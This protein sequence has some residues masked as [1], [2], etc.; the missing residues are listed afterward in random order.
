VDLTEGL[1]GYWPLDA[2]SGTVASDA[3]GLDN[4]GTVYGN[5]VATGGPVGG[6][7]DFDGSDD[8]VVIADHATLD[9]VD[10]ITIATWIRPEQKATQYVIKKARKDSV[11]GYELGL[12]RGGTIF[13]RFN[14]DSSGN[15]YRLDSNTSYPFNGQ[16]WIHVAATYD[17]TAIKIYVNGQLEATKNAVFQIAANSVALGIGA[18]DNGYR[19]LKGGMDDVRIYQRALSAAEVQLLS[20]P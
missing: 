17:G 11:D 2:P 10:S 1:V 19:G 14:E 3:S 12:S 9:P 8:R 6:A 15:D 16:D 7:L 5:P 13:V 4:D 20:S 18:Q